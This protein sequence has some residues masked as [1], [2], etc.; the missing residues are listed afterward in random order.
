MSKSLR[1]TKREAVISQLHAGRECGS[2]I[3]MFAQLVADMRE[4]GLRDL[5]MAYFLNSFGQRKMGKVFFVPQGIE[6]D[7]FAASYL[8]ALVVLDAIGIGNVGEVAE[9]ETENG[10]IHVPDPDRDDGNIADKKGFFADIDEAQLRD[11]GIAGVGEGIGEFPYDRFLCHFIGVEIHCLML[12][13]V[14]CAYI[15]ESCD[16]VLMRMCKEH[17]IE[18]ADATA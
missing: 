8:F 7:L 15:V 6:Y 9:T 10:H 5:Q 17:G 12:K 18:A 16:M 13:I 11:A 14:I 1:R 3:G 4:P 2:D